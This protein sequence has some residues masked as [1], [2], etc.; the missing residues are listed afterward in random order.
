MLANPYRT[1]WGYEA[2]EPPPAIDWSYCIGVDRATGYYPGYGSSIDKRRDQ[3][4][5][6]RSSRTHTW[7]RRAELARRRASAQ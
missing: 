4:L 2:Y 7:M 1:I 3:R 5:L 6:D